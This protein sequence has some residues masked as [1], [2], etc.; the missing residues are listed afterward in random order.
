MIINLS[1]Q[2]NIYIIIMDHLLGVDIIVKCTS[3]QI[4]FILIKFFILDGNNCSS[5]LH[6]FI[7][8]SQ[9]LIRFPSFLFLI[10]DHLSFCSELFFVITQIYRFNFFIFALVIWFIMGDIY[11]NFGFGLFLFTAE[12]VCKSRLWL[13]LLLH[14][15]Y[16]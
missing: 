1:S 13:I 15:F 8:K 7:F 16:W 6:D 9:P 4:T 2:T 12:E 11:F 10:L 14:I 3:A 5:F